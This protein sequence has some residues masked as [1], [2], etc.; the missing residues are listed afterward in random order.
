MKHVAC[1]YHNFICFYLTEND[2][3]K[4]QVGGGKTTCLEKLLSCVISCFFSYQEPDLKSLH[5]KRVEGSS[6]PF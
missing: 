6:Q 1:S 4:K 5:K 3:R 2:E